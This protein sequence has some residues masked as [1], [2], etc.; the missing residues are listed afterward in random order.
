MYIIIGGANIGNLLGSGQNIRFV[1][2]GDGIHPCAQNLGDPVCSC[3]DLR[4]PSDTAVAGVE[5]VEIDEYRRGIYLG[6][7]SYWK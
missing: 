7:N 5:V 1:A 4:Y 3:C 2:G 6:S